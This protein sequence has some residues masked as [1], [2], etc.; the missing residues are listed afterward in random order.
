MEKLLRFTTGGRKAMRHEGRHC[1]L[2]WEIPIYTK[3]EA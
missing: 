3:I 1:E 2:K